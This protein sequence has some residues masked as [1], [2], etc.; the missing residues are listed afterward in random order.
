MSEG[1][2][3][4][5]MK[6]EHFQMIMVIKERSPE[7]S[8]RTWF[9]SDQPQESVLT[10]PTE[11]AQLP[12]VSWAGAWGGDWSQ[13]PGWFL[14]RWKLSPPLSSQCLH[15]RLHSS[16]HVKPYDVT[17]VQVTVCKF[18]FSN[19]DFKIKRRGGHIYMTF[20]VGIW[21]DGTGDSTYRIVSI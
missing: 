11:A 13:R 19:I 21:G 14:R 18:Y 15:T 12:S 9:C 17:R 1:A 4:A 16:T 3:A 20:I 6:Q 2:S 5:G 8:T 10:V 7:K